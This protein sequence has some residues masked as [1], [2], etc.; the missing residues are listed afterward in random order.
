[1]RRDVGE[2]IYITFTF[3]KLL[4]HFDARETLSFICSAVDSFAL[5]EVSRIQ[6]RARGLRG[7]EEWSEEE[8]SWN[9]TVL[10]P[11]IPAGSLALLSFD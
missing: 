6:R 4:N 10:R 1:M 2:Q 3:R 7:G 5:G 9:R 11:V 8:R